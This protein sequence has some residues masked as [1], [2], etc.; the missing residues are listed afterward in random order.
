MPPLR[1]G[2]EIFK[3]PLVLPR[4]EDFVFHI[5]IPE[6]VPDPDRP[7]Y[8]LPNPP[9]DPDAQVRI[10]WPDISPQ[11]AWA[12]TLVPDTIVVGEIRL[13]TWA[14]DE[15]A[16][17]AVRADKPREARFQYLLG[18]LKLPWGASSELVYD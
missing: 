8:T 13:V 6:T 11:V 17:A 10:F 16:V 7:G 15:L 18:E 14:V 9:L 12:G 4:Y 5:E 1:I 2:P 3:V